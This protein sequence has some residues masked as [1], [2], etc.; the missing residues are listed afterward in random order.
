MKRT[1][2]QQSQLLLMKDLR[3]L[4]PFYSNLE[5]SEVLRALATTAGSSVTVQ[6]KI[7]RKKAETRR[8][9]SNRQR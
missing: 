9:E 1:M 5:P 8:L 3:N 4:G 6:Q 7:N 2:R